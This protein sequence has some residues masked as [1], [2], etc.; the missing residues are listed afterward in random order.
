MTITYEVEDNLYLNITNACPCDCVFCI[1]NNG[2]GAYG[3]DPLWLDH[4]P[5]LAEITAALDERKLDKYAQ[6]VFCGYGEPTE[7]ADA[8]CETA[9]LIKSRTK[10]PI[11]L[12]TNGLSDLIN[13]RDIV[14]EIKG[15]IDIVSISL[16]APDAAGY[17]KV[18]RPVYGEKA[19]DAM[20]AFAK[21]CRAAGIDTMFTVVDII[22]KEQIERSKELC[23]KLG[24]PL[25]IREMVK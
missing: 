22:P 25:R 2:D 16:N 15:L 12:N 20:C 9:R 11:R 4:E 21:R 13:S 14:P 19:F 10:T 5:S 18:T 23:Q 17:T 3:S 7:R 6:I 24:I 8:M 1:R